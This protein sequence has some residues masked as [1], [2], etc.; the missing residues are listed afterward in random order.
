MP[1]PMSRY[2]VS[3]AEKAATLTLAGWTLDD[4]GRWR[5]PPS[6]GIQPGPAKSLSL[7][8]AFESWRRSS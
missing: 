3:D 6:T 2:T 5:R 1:R 8:A 4:D 7:G